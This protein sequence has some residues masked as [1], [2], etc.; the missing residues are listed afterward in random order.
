MILRK[1]NAA[2][3]LVASF[4]LF[5]HAA[6]LSIWMLSKYTIQ[7]PPMI[8]SWILLGFMAAHAILSIIMA[9][10]GHKGAEKRKC[11]EYPKMNIPTYLQRATGMIMIFLIGL[12]IAGPFV[13]YQPTVLHAIGHPILFLLSLSHLSVSVGRGLITFGIG[14]AAIIKVIDVVAKILCILTLIASIV[15]FYS[16]LFAR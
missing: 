9:F 1:I 7:R 15:G 8:L 14:N 5:H 10:L 6:H 2:L 13:R 12:H 4:L 3:S 16:C 11:N